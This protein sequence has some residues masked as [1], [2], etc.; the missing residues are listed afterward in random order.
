M[1][2]NYRNLSA[3]CLA[4]MLIGGG[5]CTAQ[6]VNGQP[7][8]L[9]SREALVKGIREAHFS[10]LHIPGGISLEYRME[11][12]QSLTEPMLIWVEA[13]DGL[14]NIRW[15]H[16]KSR[17][18]GKML[19]E[20]DKTKVVVPA[21]RQGNYDFEAHSGVGQDSTWLG[22]ITNTRHSFSASTCYPLKLLFF[23]ESDQHYKLSDDKSF[24][25]GRLL[26]H[27]LEQY[28]YEVLRTEEIQGLTCTVVSRKNA[29]M[30]D[31]IWI[32]PASSY[33][34]CRREWHLPDGTLFGRV[35][36]DDLREIA[37]RVWI[38]FH[39]TEE[40]FGGPKRLDKRVLK[41]DLIVKKARVGDLRTEELEIVLGNDVKY[42]ENHITG[43]VVRKPTD[44]L[45]DPFEEAIGKSRTA[46]YPWQTILIIANIVVVGLVL[47]NALLRRRASRT[48]AGSPSGHI[49]TDL[50]TPHHT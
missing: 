14:L 23:S 36:N 16:L 20:R 30:R 46:R 43:E 4:L 9:L 50:Q 18:E 29:D 2:A 8:Q 38:P 26:P 22:Q 42:I 39:Q 41:T 12:E 37:P 5:W 27:A 32:A 15:P 1:N 34:V 10:L 44:P 6:T 47:A 19:V 31:T 48:M 25:S 33:T 40:I 28:P 13:L 45:Y 7:P 35:V 24:K 11:I 3:V 21:L 49:G 17:N